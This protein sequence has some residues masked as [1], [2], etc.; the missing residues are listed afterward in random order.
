M[1]AFYESFINGLKNLGND[2][3]IYNQATINTWGK[4]LE[5]CPK[6]IADEIKNFSPDC[7][8]LF[9]NSFYDISN[10]I[11]CPII[12]YEV[13]TPMYYSNKNN[14]KANPNRYHFFVS[15]TES[16]RIIKEM[17][18]VNE[19]NIV[20]MPFFTSMQAENLP[21]YKNICFIGSKFT[22]EDPIPYHHLQNKSNSK[23]II[24]EYMNYYKQLEKNPYL[25]INDFR[26][27]NHELINTIKNIINIE[28][29]IPYI[30]DIKRIGIL[31]EIADLGLQLYGTNNW[32][33]L[34]YYP[35]LTMSYQNKVI[36]SFKDNQDI[37][38]SSKIGI[39][40]N[41]HQAVTGFSWR[42]C[43][44]MAT[45]CCLVSQ[46]TSDLEKLFPHVDLPTFKNKYEAKEICKYLLEN[47]N[48]RKEIVRNSNDAINK[49]YR[50]KHLI[51]KIEEHININLSTP[52]KQEKTCKI[53]VFLPKEKI[54][55]I[56]CKQRFKNFINGFSLALSQLPIIEKMYN[57]KIKEKLYCAIEKYKTIN[58]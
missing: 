23:E 3:L 44:I 2:V 47:E 30:S 35:Q 48:K 49:K 22:D 8:F 32:Q 45:N 40:I 14:L 18:N 46:Y 43:D 7:A 41:H 12:V 11:D 38:N 54:I 53:R 36:Y 31:S 13:D 57:D 19:K 20:H 17:Y 56:S 26:T 37:Y 58:Y 55:K 6:N 34:Q 27:K 39:N 52:C 29:L 25:E 9:N 21:I 33:K 24:K 50:F 42:V 51:K 15:Q 28:I 16:T 1:P 10:I 5:E 4:N